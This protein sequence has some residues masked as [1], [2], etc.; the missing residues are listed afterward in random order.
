MVI[1]PFVVA[2]FTGI[3]LQFSN[4]CM[5]YK[6]SRFARS[7]WQLKHYVRKQKQDVQI[8]YVKSGR[9]QLRMAVFGDTTKPKL[10]MIHGSPGS[11]SEYDD[12]FVN[13]SLISKYCMVSFDRPGYGYSNF[14]EVD[15]SILRQSL[16]IYSAFSKKFPSDTF[17]IIGNSFGGPVAASI[18]GLANEKVKKL[19]LVASAI[20]PGREKIY[21][22]S[23]IIDKP[24]Y[25]WLFPSIVTMPN[26][27]KLSHKKSLETIKSLLEKVSAEI[28]MMHGTQDKLI[29]F[30]NTEYAK[31]VFLSA[32]KL[33]I[34]PI[35]GKDHPI[36]WT[37]KNIV[38]EQLL[39]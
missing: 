26:D 7:D 27:E 30:T 10:L 20:A 28:V 23:F 37:D 33:S 32:E 17:S 6:L 31:K 24:A 21:P 8:Y 36:L 15:T 3:V 38:L 34:I 12:Y 35:E 25:R 39:K 1:R 4:G 5:N 2:I 11:M 16:L 22:I 19:F 9:Y 18:A 13:P 29:Y 14:G